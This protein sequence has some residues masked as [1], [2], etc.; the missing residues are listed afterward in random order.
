MSQG[1]DRGK[2]KLRMVREALPVV[3][4]K[5]TICARVLWLEGAEEGWWEAME[6]SGIMQH[7]PEEERYTGSGRNLEC[8]EGF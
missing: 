4:G 3:G 7:V 8:S 5:A 1:R 6:E 2:R